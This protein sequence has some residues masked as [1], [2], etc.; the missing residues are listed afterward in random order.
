VIRRIAILLLAAAGTGLALGGAV[1]TP[2]LPPLEMALHAIEQ[3]PRVQSARWAVTGEEAGSDRLAAGDAETK[4]VLEGQQRRERVD[5]EDTFAEWNVGVERELRLPEKARLDS[6]LGRQR[7]GVARAALADAFHETGRELLAGWFAWVRAGL[8]VEEWERQS[9]L[10]AQELAVV[11]KRIQAGDA[12]QLERLAAE[13]ALAQSRA[14]LAQASGRLQVARTDLA[15][16]FPSL[17]LPRT[18]RLAEPT[19]V[20]GSAERWRQQIMAHSHSLIAAQAESR[21]WQT[22]LARQNAYELPNPTVG[23]FYGQERGGDEQIVRLGVS[24]PLPGEGRRADSRQARAQAESANAMEAAE[25]LRTKAEAG[26][27]YETAVNAF[28]VWRQAQAA[29]ASMGRNATMVSKAYSAGETG[30]N[31]V[32]VARRQAVEATLTARLAQANAREAYLR[33]LLDAHQL[34]AFESPEEGGDHAH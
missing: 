5:P 15:A 8:E 29:A 1:A 17:S 4:L 11:E 7:V 9:G 2:D 10:L 13:A 23:L 14:S 30:I 16:R 24:V 28:E 6:E 21:R 18:V 34:W 19:A 31:E 22:E 12:A 33:L 20:S 3:A 27:A 32:L 25:A 26:G